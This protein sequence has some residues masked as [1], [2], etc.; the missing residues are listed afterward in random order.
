MMVMYVE[1]Q[2]AAAAAAIVLMM[3]LLVLTMMTTE[4]LRQMFLLA[5]EQLLKQI[6]V[7]LCCGTLT[8]T[9]ISKKRSLFMYLPVSKHHMRLVCALV[10]DGYDEKRKRG[11]KGRYI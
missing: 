7:R 10:N 3:L 8:E 2:M 6:L 9:I 4:S 5:D 11:V 1:S